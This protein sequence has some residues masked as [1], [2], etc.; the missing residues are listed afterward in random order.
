MADDK[1]DD[2]KDKLD[3]RAEV[4]SDDAEED[5][6]E[7]EKDLDLEDRKKTTAA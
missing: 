3:P 5:T 7:Q 2:I 6:D 1:E 4:P